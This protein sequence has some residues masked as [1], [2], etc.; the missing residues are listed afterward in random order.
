MT[1]FGFWQ[2][3]NQESV[4]VICGNPLGFDRNREV[5]INI[6]FTVADISLVIGSFFRDILANSFY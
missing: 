1:G 5:N 4:I 2:K 3:N 6:E